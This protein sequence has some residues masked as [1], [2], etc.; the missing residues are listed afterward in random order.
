M[1]NEIGPGTMKTKVLGIQ[2]VNLVGKAVR[3]IKEIPTEADW[4]AVPRVGSV[5][6]V[7]AQRELPNIGDV[8]FYVVFPMRCADVATSDFKLGLTLDEFEVV[9]E[10]GDRRW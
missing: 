1:G 8:M 10:I 2:A 7:V 9:K 6:K 4:I 5:G 3:V